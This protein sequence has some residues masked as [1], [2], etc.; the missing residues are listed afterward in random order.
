MITTLFDSA[1]AQ[2]RVVKDTITSA[3]DGLALPRVAVV[4]KEAKNIGTVTNAGE[5][6]E[7]AMQEIDTND[8]S[9]NRELKGMNNLAGEV[10]GV[11]IAK[12]SSSAEG[13]AITIRGVR[14]P[15][16][17]ITSHFLLWMVWALVAKESMPLLAQLSNQHCEAF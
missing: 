10:T 13:S 4:V 6:L 17:E 11:Q 1:F 5:A 14:S 8:L 3:S 2:Q 16:R 9:S 12:I 7:S 15:P